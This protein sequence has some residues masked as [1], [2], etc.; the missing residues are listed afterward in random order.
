ME[1][2]RYKFLF[3]CP[4]AEPVLVFR[5]TRAGD[6]ENVAR[7]IAKPVAKKLHAEEAVCVWMGPAGTKIPSRVRKEI[8]AS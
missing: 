2:V 5:E 4:G 7:S 8:C 6:A 1:K 3:V